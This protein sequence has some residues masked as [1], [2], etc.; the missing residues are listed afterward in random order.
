[1]CCVYGC[2]NDCTFNV[3]N[4][5]LF[6]NWVCNLENIQI[7]K[8]IRQNTLILATDEKS[9]QLALALDFLVYRIDWLLSNVRDFTIDENAPLRFGQGGHRAIVALKMIFSFDIISLGYNV[10]HQ[11]TDVVWFKNILN[12]NFLKNNVLDIVMT[13]DGRVDTLGPGNGGLIIIN[14]NCKTKIFLQTIIEYIGLIIL[15]K[16]EQMIWNQ[17]LMAYDFRQIMFEMLNPT[18]FVNGD[19]W[20]IE[21]QESSGNR[22]SNDIWFAHASWTHTH[23]TKITKFKIIGAWYLSQNCSCYNVSIQ[24]KPKT[25]AKANNSDSINTSRSIFIKDLVPDYPEPQYYV[26]SNQKNWSY[27][28]SKEIQW[29]K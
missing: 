28:D 7:D 18:K 5:Y 17:F 13:S 27:P 21:L 3:K 2:C 6:L 16:N 9:E 23:M 10:I 15:V 14:S 22:L 12:F 24:L 1:M 25:K 19:Q 20:S 8:L 29:W 11:D 4:S 26:L